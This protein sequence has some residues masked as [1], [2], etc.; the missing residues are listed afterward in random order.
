[1][2]SRRDTEPVEAKDA[3]RRGG[4]SGAASGHPLEND[5]LTSDTDLVLHHKRA[6]EDAH[7]SG[8]VDM[9][10]LMVEKDQPTRW[11][12]REAIPRCQGRPG[13]APHLHAWG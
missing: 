4:G 8:P 12:S 10:G 5:G 2:R 11:R 6:L 7:R 1:M 9:Y 13:A 3:F